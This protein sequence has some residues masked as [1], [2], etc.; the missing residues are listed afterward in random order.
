MSARID[1]KIIMI[2]NIHFYHKCIPKTL[3]NWLEFKKKIVKQFVKNAILFE[4]KQQNNFTFYSKIH[5]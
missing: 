3:Y 2:C 4:N 1:T 5:D